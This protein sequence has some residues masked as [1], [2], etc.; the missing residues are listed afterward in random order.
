M[1]IKE[2]K[3]LKDFEI[4]FDNNYEIKYNR[5]KDTLS[6]NKKCESANN[7]IENFYSIDKTKGNIDSVN[8]LIGKNGSGKTNIL[9]MLNLSKERRKIDYMIIYKSVENNEDFIIEKSGLSKFIKIKESKEIKLKNEL[10][11]YHDDKNYMKNTGVIKFSFKEKIMS[12]VMREEKFEEEYRGE[13]KTNL[14]K[15]NRGLENGSKKKLYNYLLSINKKENNENFENAYLT[16]LIP[17]LYKELKKSKDEEIK[18]RIKIEYDSNS[19]NSLHYQGYS[20]NEID[21]QLFK[22][23]NIDKKD[24]K[25]IVLHNYFNRI[26]LEIALE[27]LKQKN[28]EIFSKEEMLENKNEL[29]ELLKNESSYTKKFE[30]LLERYENLVNNV[31][32]FRKE[33]YK[34]IENVAN[35]ISSIVSKIE[36]EE[37]IYIENNDE[38]IAKIKINCKNEDEEVLK[39]LE[40]YD[41]F[42]TPKIEEKKRYLIDFGNSLFKEVEFIKIEE[43][44]LSEG[45][46]V[47]LGYFSTLYSILNGEF[48]N[49]KY[50]T[51]LFDEVETFLHPE[52]SRR[53]LYELIEELEKYEDKKFKLI[54]ATH[55]PFLIA[56]VLAKDCIYLSKNKKGKIKAEI[57]EDVKT[58]GANII[59]LFKNTMFLESTFGKFAT[60]K[61]KGLVDKIE[62]AEKYSDIKHEVD[63]IID[64]I[65]EKL[66]SNKLKS[67]IE[68]KFENKDEEK[69]EEYYRKKIE[70][71][72]AKLDE[73]EKKENN[74]NSKK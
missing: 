50:V 57:K 37:E 56:D 31:I 23:Y 7:N 34:I 33:K 16:L 5:D 61:I 4:T 45:E 64:E 49:K 40:E 47:K 20:S 25:Y 10:Y 52:W 36:S 55:S 70:E 14:Y 48:K 24:L 58:F 1:Y 21:E 44:G 69:D 62:K 73:L 17:D 8:L 6:I 32:K 2:Y 19:D 68:S 53:F 59:D 15:L 60:E 3:G 26:Y 39:L 35:L 46:K 9:E 41:D 22:L 13:S 30:I 29:L 74:R 63:F 71:Y 27:T 18:R 42:H 72:Q 28:Q 12:A 54:F 43:E 38:I 66:I 11:E 65:G 67:M 51:L